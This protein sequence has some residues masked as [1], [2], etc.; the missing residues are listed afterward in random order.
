M[1]VDVIR[2]TLA[3]TRAATFAVNLFLKDYGVAPTGTGFFVSSEGWFVTA[4][5]VVT[6]DGTPNGPVRNDFGAATLTTMI[7]GMGNAK[8]LCMFMSLD[9]V[10][11]KHDFALLK[12]DFQQNKA[13]GF[14]EG[15]G[16]PYIE[17]STRTLDEGEPVYSF[18]YPLSEPTFLDEVYVVDGQPKPMGYLAHSPRVTSAIVSSTVEKSRARE[19]EADTL[20]Y[21]LDKAINYGNSGGPIVAVETG[22][23]HALCSRFQPVIIPQTHLR[24]TLGDLAAIA[25]PS[26]YGIVANL[27]HHEIVNVLRQRNVPLSEI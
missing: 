23:V 18:G 22:K 9:H 16:F 8:R 21:V 13:R 17:I 5:H 14:V 26:L 27:A 7:P 12:V 6:Q 15:E 1:G 20:V 3:A 10:D 25:V 24:A 11:P 4:A 2:K 19:T